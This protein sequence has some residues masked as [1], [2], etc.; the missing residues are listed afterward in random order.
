MIEKYVAPGMWDYLTDMSNYKKDLPI[1]VDDPFSEDQLDR[2]NAIFNELLSRTPEYEKLPGDQEEFRGKE[3]YD[4]KK[5]IHMSREMLE[6]EA[7]KDVEQTIDGVLKP[8]Y[9]GEVK[10]AH[11][12]YIDYDLR[13][14]EGKYAP[15]LPPH[16]DNSEDIITFNYML[17]GN[18][19]WDLFV[20]GQRYTLRKGQAI[21]FS[22]L[23]QPH[24][25]PKRKWKQGEFVKILSFD[26][27]PLH[28]FRF[29]G[30]EYHLDPMKYQDR[31]EKYI[32]LVNMHPKMQQA[33]QLYN[34][35]GLEDGIP[36]SEHA[37]ILEEN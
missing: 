27:S 8:L 30:K 34:A 35:V 32:R 2:L 22:A 33:W 21:V 17:D 20:D 37:V 18:I 28:D 29:T 19:D 15:S 12:Q 31:L 16:I 24:F 13:H 23:N 25:R 6:F 4:P 10:L 1:Y 7:P 5:V 11:Y 9:D 3:W 26:Y 36:E 14:G